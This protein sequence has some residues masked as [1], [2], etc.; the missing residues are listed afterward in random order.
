MS[1]TDLHEAAREDDLEKVKALLKDKPDLV[2][3][4]DN[5]GRTPLHVVA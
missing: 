5:N 1:S 4:K 2:F 3:S